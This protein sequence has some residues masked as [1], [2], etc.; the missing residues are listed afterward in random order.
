MSGA[1]CAY[2]IGHG[3]HLYSGGVARGG[4]GEGSNKTAVGL[5]SHSQTKFVLHFIAKIFPIHFSRVIG[6]EFID[7]GNKIK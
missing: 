2:T 1:L 4:G 7:E 6:S 5:L 3:C